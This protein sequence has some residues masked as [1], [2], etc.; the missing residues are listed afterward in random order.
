MSAWDQALYLL[1]EAEKSCTADVAAK[2]RTFVVNAHAED[3][4][5]EGELGALLGTNL[6]WHGMLSKVR[7]LKLR[8][9]RK[10]QIE[11]IV[12]V[13]HG[14]DVLDAACHTIAVQIGDEAV[15]EHLRSCADAVDDEDTKQKLRDFAELF[16]FE[17][18]K[19]GGTRG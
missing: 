11:K 2:I 5:R 16:A 15:Y 3:K 7:D 13:L 17:F 8:E 9:D 4:T 18:C 1:Q 19:T 10:I 12:A 6:S 14:M